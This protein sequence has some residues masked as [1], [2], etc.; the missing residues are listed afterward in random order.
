MR[1]ADT[2]VAALVNDESRLAR[3]VKIGIGFLVAAL[4][5]FPIYMLVLDSFKSQRGI[6]LDPIGWPN[7]N[8]FSGDN[9]SVAAARME[10]FNAFFNSLWITVASTL[11]IV[12]FAGMAAWV[13]VRYKGKLSSA[14]YY[15]FA[16]AMLI[17][18]QCVMLP[19]MSVLSSV[20]GLNP[21]GLV[22]CYLGFGSSLSIMLYAGFIKGIPQ[23]LEE[24]ATIDGCGMFRMF[25][26][27]VF[28]LLSPI[29]VTV[30]ILNIM[31]IW[32]DFLLP[33]LVINANPAWRTL[34]LRTF[35][36]FGQFSSRWDL[37]TAALILS[38]LPIVIFYLLAQRKIIK[39]VVDGA[40]K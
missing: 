33:N 30:S 14:I 24:A 5:L 17:P 27:V 12:V 16:I 39:G 8:T 31:W 32:N 2:R 28:P 4:F 23:E 36:F 7:A 6:F 40:I 18:F 34:P 21:A 26:R 35:Y 1:K 10:Y 37:A 20:G 22:F 13:L 29:A 19:L 38:M 9:Y 11:I 25:W 3:G 15:L